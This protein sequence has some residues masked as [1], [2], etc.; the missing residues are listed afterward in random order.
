MTYSA[1]TAT[2][3]AYPAAITHEKGKDGRKSLITC[4]TIS[5]Y[6]PLRDLGRF[7]CN[8]NTIDSLSNAVGGSDA[9]LSFNYR[10]EY[11]AQGGFGRDAKASTLR[12]RINYRTKR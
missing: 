3:K 11:V 12:S 7:I 1:T 4:V 9:R 6:V 10:C 2:G 8:R 5:R